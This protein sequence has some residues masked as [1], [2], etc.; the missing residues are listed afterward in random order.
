MNELCVG[1]GVETP[2]VVVGD[3]QGGECL[4]EGGAQSQKSQVA[5]DDIGLSF[6]FIPQP[7]RLLPP[8]HSSRRHPP[9][10]FPLLY[11]GPGQAVSDTLKEMSQ[12]LLWAP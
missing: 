1:S 9:R 8:L 4:M 2:A 6:S 12:T 3:G 11:H 5:S 7:L 10:P